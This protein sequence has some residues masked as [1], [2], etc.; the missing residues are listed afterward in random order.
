MDWCFW[1]IDC[2]HKSLVFVNKIFLSL[3]YG[4]LRFVR[5]F[6]HRADGNSALKI[7]DASKKRSS[8]RPKF[9]IAFVV[10]SQ[11][12]LAVGASA[13]SASSTRPSKIKVH[14]LTK[15]ACYEW[16]D[17]FVSPQG[18]EDFLSPQG[19][20]S[21]LPPAFYAVLA[22]KVNCNQ[23]HHFQVISI[24]SQDKFLK[25][26]SSSGSSMKYCEKT[27]SVSN[28][29]LM[30]NQ[31]LNWS[32]MEISKLTKRYSCFVTGKVTVKPGKEK[33]FFYEELFN[34]LSKQ[35]GLGEN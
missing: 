22:Q 19:S 31:R 33:V 9:L 12:V 35:Q 24:D 18:S 16:K 29:S 2:V 7:L 34:P 28:Y 8:L 15:N 11:I 30:E 13:V 26:K 14:A 20:Q 17:K 25:A 21:P 27:L 4:R 32:L 3:K 1:D 10:T 23:R 5:L 6:L